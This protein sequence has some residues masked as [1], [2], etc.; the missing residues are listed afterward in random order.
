DP[1]LGRA[2]AELVLVLERDPVLHLLAVDV[3]AALGLEVLEEHAA[4]LD[5][6]LG[7]L[8]ADV[9][10]AELDLGRPSGADL[11]RARRPLEDLAGSLAAEDRESRQ[12][13]NPPVGRTGELGSPHPGRP[14]RGPR[15]VAFVILQ[16]DPASSY[17]GRGLDVRP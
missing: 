12:H 16:P 17:R 13:G 1:Q 8:E 14:R 5:D 2:D 10:V 15:S 9:L 7:V 11:V 6:D 3:G 4:V